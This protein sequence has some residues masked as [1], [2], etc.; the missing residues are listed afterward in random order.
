MRPAELRSPSAQGAPRRKGTCSLWLKRNWLLLAL[1]ALALAS[2]GLS[3]RLYIVPCD[4]KTSY[5][6]T[7]TTTVVNLT[8][9]EN[10]TVLENVRSRRGTPTRLATPSTRTTCRVREHHT[11]TQVT[12]TET[13]L[14]LENVTK[15]ENVTRE[16]SYN[17]LQ[18]IN[19]IRGA[20]RPT[21]LTGLFTHRSQLK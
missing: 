19:Q 14:Q 3:I 16:I 7:N 1:F 8:S 21:R 15:Y 2:A 20:S 13:V 11:P 12:V 6:T 18:C 10:V 17:V 4:K 5:E 9:Y